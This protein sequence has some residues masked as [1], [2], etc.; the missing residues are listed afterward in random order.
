ML[1][2]T[3]L[4]FGLLSAV[5]MSDFFEAESKSELQKDA[6]RIATEIDR[7]IEKNIVIVDEMKTNS[8][9]VNIIASLNSRAEKRQ[10]P[11][12]DTISNELLAIK[13]MD[14]NI[15]LAY[16]AVTK[17]NDIITSKYDFDPAPD[18]DLNNRTWYTETVNA[19][20][21]IVTN[22]YLDVVTQ[23]MVVTIATPVKKDG[24]LIGAM[25]LDLQVSDIS[26]LMD[27]YKV[28][29]SGYTL[30]LN[31]DGSI[32][33]QPDELEIYKTE[34]VDPFA[35]LDKYMTELTSGG[36]GIIDYLLGNNAKY[37]A[38]VPTQSSNWIVVT[39]IPKSEVMAPVNQFILLLSSIMLAL[40]LFLVVFIRRMT[41]QIS[42]PIVEIAQS[43]SRFS[44]DNSQI[45]LPDHYYIRED[46]IGI[47]SHGLHQMSYRLQAYFA[48]IKESNENLNQEI[49]KRK[50][51]QSRHEMILNLLSRTNEGIFILD[52]HFNC[53]Y[54]NAAFTQLIETH[55]NVNFLANNILINQEIADS[56]AFNP[57]WTGELKYQNKLILVM[58][59]TLIKEESLYYYIGNITDV[60][61]FREI[62]QDIYFL[63]YY[64]HLT[65]LNNKQYLDESCIQLIAKDHDGSNRFALILINID[66][67]RI[68]NEA[69]G[70]E[71]GNLV[72][73]ALANRLKSLV[74]EEDIL[75]RLGN[76]EFGILKKNIT[77]NTDF[78][79][80]MLDFSRNLTQKI[81]I[82]DESQILG[83][84][85][86]ISL[87]PGDANQ[88][89]AL[90]KC[91]ISALNNVKSK[92]GLLFEFYDREINRLSIQKYKIQNML[93]EAL[94]RQE[95]VL[96]YQPQ[97]D[98]IN[99]KIIGLEALIRWNSPEGMMPPSFFIKIA[100]ESGQ[101][102]P[103]GE[104]VLEQACYFGRK[105]EQM[106][107]D[108]PIA[109]NLSSLQFKR[110]Y[111]TELI[112]STLTATRFAPERL[113]LEITEGILM[114]NEEECEEI[115]K[116][117]KKMG[118]QVSIDDFGT[119]YSSLNYLKNFAVDKI[120][121]DR[122]FIKGVP[123]FDNGTI[124]KVIIELAENFGLQVIA[125]G[126]ETKEQ[127]AFLKENNCFAVQGYYFSC[128]LPEER[129][130]S[131]IEDFKSQNLL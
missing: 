57:I 100:E 85:I 98:I 79:D 88:Y 123:D 110:P 72:L 10:H 52:Q 8:D 55:E 129:L 71:Y 38:Y 81:M 120:K 104:W 82:E 87:Y 37:I 1:G 3:F 108:I 35:Y 97:V 25:A 53:I 126:V 73:I 36:A 102:L 68:I 54:Q 107:Y 105:L 18:Y 118:I 13:A 121:I 66:D 46:E 86:G 58:R 50:A 47:L 24:T 17:T 63:K 16:L 41:K 7:F 6:R 111:I 40:L 116:I 122:S 117:F 27:N 95:F 92:K 28:G 2:L 29:N 5:M 31:K 109:V 45:N 103:I 12:F 22:P 128:P 39:V 15:S 70:F 64:D 4:I 26:N 19:G 61:A 65:K 21:T 20:K 56:L 106:G 60:T 59:L 124:A 93:R 44:E 89:S 14:Q 49:E 62:E 33:Y 69:K 113:E 34:G 99:H 77:S 91:A 23:N 32:F 127:I 51:I 80:Y 130:M 11:Q 96:Y 112:S 101:I 48:E 119:G 131:W 115:L 76:D 75:V 30:L 74:S 84:S 83:F 43:V 94:N 125:E 114:S 42:E 78:Y 9:Y 67:F 90:L